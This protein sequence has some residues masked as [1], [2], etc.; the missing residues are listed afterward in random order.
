M[1]NSTRRRIGTRAASPAMMHENT[2]SRTATASGGTPSLARE[3]ADDEAAALIRQADGDTTGAALTSSPPRNPDSESDDGSDSS[4]SPNDDAAADAVAS[5]RRTAQRLDELEESQPTPHAGLAA[6]QFAAA[7]IEML[8]GSATGLGTSAGPETTSDQLGDRTR[9]H[10]RPA[11]ARRLQARVSG[12]VARGLPADGDA[13]DNWTAANGY[14]R[15][16]AA[17]APE[18]MPPAP[19]RRATA[20]TGV[21]A[22][23]VGARPSR[24]AARAAFEGILRTRGDAVPGLVDEATD[25]RK[26]ANVIRL[27]LV[28]LGATQPAALLAHELI[29]R[30]DFMQY[31]LSDAFVKSF[32]RADYKPEAFSL[33]AFNRILTAA[34]ADGSGASA[35]SPIDLV[36]GNCESFADMQAAA[37]FGAQLLGVIDPG[38]GEQFVTFVLGLVRDPVFQSMGS[39]RG[40]RPA[41]RIIDDQ[42]R[43]LMSSANAWATYVAD[44]PAGTDLS[45]APAAPSGL[46]FATSGYTANMVQLT[47]VRSVTSAAHAPAPP[48]PA[49]M[50]TGPRVRNG[51]PK[52]PEFAFTGKCSRGDACPLAHAPLTE[53]E[54]DRWTLSFRRRPRGGRAGAGDKK[55]QPGAK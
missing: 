45:L 55:R 8:P 9:V 22:T 37:H 51:T 6:A 17:T 41:V 23:A 34:P 32:S 33:D 24:D 21:R 1:P 12:I 53:T 31:S 46:F 30:V 26:L 25:H 19:W 29:T 13:A 38:L 36:S 20:A 4:D 28:F 40:T 14:G 43:V 54:S 47:M 11:L 16:S 52:C 27:R 10:D 35:A 39:A 2:R 48:P 49:Q 5:R 18:A 15:R 7:G 50:S 3:E 42:M 44:A